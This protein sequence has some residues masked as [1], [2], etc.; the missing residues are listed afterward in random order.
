MA[1]SKGSAAAVEAERGDAPLHPVATKRGPSGRASAAPAKAQGKGRKAT[2]APD[3]R[4]TGISGRS[5]ALSL[6]L[7]LAMWIVRK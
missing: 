2:A 7:S 5:W 6:L 1:K 3:A 4:L